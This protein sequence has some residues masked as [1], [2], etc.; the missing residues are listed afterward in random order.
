MDIFPSALFIA[1]NILACRL[2]AFSKPNSE[3]NSSGT[4]SVDSLDDVEIKYNTSFLV[5]LDNT[6]KDFNQHHPIVGSLGLTRAESTNSIRSDYSLGL[7]RSVSI[8]NN[9]NELGNLCIGIKFNTF[10]N[11][12]IYTGYTTIGVLSI[13]GLYYLQHKGSTE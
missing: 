13:G 6:D 3:E 4:I 1:A 8:A 9:I 12:L 2:F 11:I 7:S 5:D 10:V